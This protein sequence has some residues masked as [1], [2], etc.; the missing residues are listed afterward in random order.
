MKNPTKLQRRFVRRLDQVEQLGAAEKQALAPVGERF[1]F[2]ATPYYLGLIDWND[3][4]DPIRRIVVPTTDEIAETDDILDASN[5]TSNTKV[6]GL[7]HKYGQTALLL[8]T[9]V[10]AAYCRFCFRKRL[11]MDEVHETSLNISEGLRYIREHP[12]ISNVLL[13][14]GD[15]LM[16]SSGRL[17]EVFR[18]LREIDHVRIIRLGTKVPAFEPQRITEDPE[19]LKAIRKY[20]E[21]ERR[22]YVMAHF[23]HPRELTEVA[24]KGLRLL[25]ESGAIVLN[26]TPLLRGVTDHPD[27]IVELFNRLSY[28]GVPP[29]YLFQCR[30]TEGNDTFK[31]TLRDG[32]RLFDEAMVR[33]SGLAKRARYVM[34]HETGKIQILGVTAEYILMKYHQAKYPSDQ[35]RILVLP[36]REGAAWL[37]DLL[38][39]V[40]S[41]LPTVSWGAASEGSS[42]F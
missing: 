27:T 24:R 33:M 30:P 11:F 15:S 29:Y 13:T 40:G 38:P 2:R 31:V 5:E 4:D 6:H 21:P 35:N 23:N 19:L 18:K 25:L 26:Q 22:I 8:V 34:S 32:C 16:M 3:P 41:E 10:C 42:F 7:Q 39:E 9:E 37:D 20:S 17:A 36:W 1:V 12:E 14:G 28:M